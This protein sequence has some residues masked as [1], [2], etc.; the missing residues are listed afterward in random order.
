MKKQMNK[1][2]F[3]ILAAVGFS[4]YSNAQDGKELFENFCS[5]CHKINDNSTGPKLKGVRQL[6]TDAEELDLMY[7][8]VRNPLQLK[9]SGKSKRALVAWDYSTTNM[10]A[11]NVTNDQIDAIFDYVD[12]WQPEPKIET[13]TVDGEIPVTLVQNYKENQRMFYWLIGTMVALLIAIIVMASSIQ[14]FLKTD[15]FK[16]RMK[17]SYERD[18]AGGGI[19]KMTIVALILGSLSV[20]ATSLANTLDTGA[21]E[22]LFKITSS[23]LYLIGVI[24]I[25]LLLVLLY[26]V[27]LFKSFY[28]MT[29]S[30]EQ[31][32][33]KEEEGITAKKIN[34]I[35]TDIVDIEDEQ[36]ILLD[37]EYDG[38]QE[39]DNN[40]P[41]W[42]VWGFYAT[43]VFAVIYLFNYHVFGTADLQ[44]AE[45]EKEVAEA[46]IAITEYR[47]KMAMNVDE[48]NVTL[49]TESTDL[50]TGKALYAKNCQSC[51]ME[52]GRGDIGP[53]LTDDYWIY[54]ND[55]ASVFKTIKYG[56]PNGMPDHEKKLNP[57]ELQQVSSYILFLEYAKGKDP[58][59]ELIKKVVA[60]EEDYHENPD[61]ANE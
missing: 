7:E 5:T 40:L 29:L 4:L 38:I 13:E 55:I 8:W 51:H 28:K 2:L 19:G 34:K 25:L 32:V 12:N 1:Y 57:I 33:E 9:E 10:S 20:P 47:T 16:K 22:V 21:D 14:S 11:Q 56:A 36:S 23:D 60:E 58:E 52:D 59:G 39:L 45:Y 18:H 35:L 24:N 41:P 27:R 49:M 54:G 53:N 37:H 46:E 42:W 15:Y 44:V 6:W 17:E 61:S 3:A 48:F 30:P 43:I 31:L 26:Q 50:N